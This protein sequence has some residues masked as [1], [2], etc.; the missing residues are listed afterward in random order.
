MRPKSVIAVTGLITMECKRKSKQTKVIEI[1]IINN[2]E[3]RYK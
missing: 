2:L 1:G 3:E